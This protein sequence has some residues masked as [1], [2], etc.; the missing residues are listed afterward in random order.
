MILEL[1]GDTLQKL[2]A[3]DFAALSRR[4]DWVLKLQILERI[5]AQRPEYDWNSPQLKHLDFM[6]ASLG[7]G[8]YWA[9]ESQGAVDKIVSDEEVATLR[10]APPDNTRAWTRAQ[11]LQLARPEQV[12]RMDWDSIT[13][14]LPRG[15]SSWPF[16]TTVNLANPLK[17]TKADCACVFERSA[18]L[19]EALELL[20]AS[21]NSSP[22]STLQTTP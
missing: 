15:T 4:L 13:F 2:G 6:Y 18:N 17:F 10:A 8:L 12:E 3:R 7:D 16:E 21:V 20:G 9:C 19:E 1:W 14:S 5:R 22:I 11:L